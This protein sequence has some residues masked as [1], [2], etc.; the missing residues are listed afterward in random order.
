MRIPVLCSPYP[1]EILTSWLDRLAIVNGIESGDYLLTYFLDM[2]RKQALRALQLHGLVPETNRLQQILDCGY[3]APE[4]TCLFSLAPVCFP[5]MPD[6][7]R[8]RYDAFLQNGY[9]GEH[10][11]PGLHSDYRYCK[12]C[13]EGDVTA[14]R[15][16]YLRRIHQVAG[17]THCPEHGTP[18][19]S[20]KTDEIV[21]SE[22]SITAYRTRYSSFVYGIL[23]CGKI[24]TYNEVRNAVEQRVKDMA[25]YSLQECEKYFPEGLQPVSDTSVYLALSRL[26]YG[27]NMSIIESLAVCAIIFGNF[28]CFREYIER[29]P[30]YGTNLN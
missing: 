12:S 5:F 7:L 4:L 27:N 1:D 2:D 25:L 23:G 18:L 11:L 10:P 15:M 28:E 24:Y 17:I 19:L 29:S 20:A 30:C 16:P 8:K 3:T 22:N 14:G 6:G 26:A 21:T 13:E 9:C